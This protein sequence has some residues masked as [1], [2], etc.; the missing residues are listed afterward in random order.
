MSKE[1]REAVGAIIL[2]E[3]DKIVCFRRADFPENWQGPEGGIE[4]NEM[5]DIA[6]KRE[7]YE[8]IGLRENDY[9]L[10]KKGSKFFSYLY[11]DGKKNQYGFIGQEKLFFLIKLKS[12]NVNF[13]YDVLQDEIEF[14]ECKAL[15]KNSDLLE[16][17]PDFKREMYKNVL[18]DFELL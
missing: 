15:D 13:K 14:L 3:N 9:T 5:L 2:D 17:V 18:I 12:N 7:I 6:I 16:L 8:E 1:Y 11:K 4:K 10:L